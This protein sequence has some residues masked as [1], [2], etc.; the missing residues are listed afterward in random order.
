[1]SLG[2]VL[3]PA[4]VGSNHSYPATY[5]GA[6][7][8]GGTVEFDVSA[9]GAG[10]TRFAISGVSTTCGTVN[11]TAAGVFPIA[12]DA[13][14]NGS[15]TA[16]GLRFNGSFPAAQQAQGTLSFRLGGFPGCTSDNV[17]WT[18]RT[19][20]PPP[21]FTAPQSKINS[22]PSGSTESRKATFRFRSSESGS[23]FQCKL[24]RKPWQGCRSPKTYRN[25]K[26][27]KHTFKVRA[28]DSAGNVDPTPAKRTWRVESRG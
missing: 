4:A 6:A 27:G 5:S 15:P 8:S 2:G 22:G 18:A 14:S 12:N 16:I 24:D 3:V 25:L 11:G 23:T 19:S 20:T 1:M 17:S 28:R 21:D 10:V 7:A 9:D 13:F 26:A